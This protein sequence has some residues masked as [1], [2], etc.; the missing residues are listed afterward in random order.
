[1]AI[2][3]ITQTI[4][5][6]SL[7]LVPE[8]TSSAVAVIGVTSS[9]TA[10]QVYAYQSADAI[11]DLR[12]DLG[13]G[14][15]VEAAAYHLS[16]NGS[17]VYV[18]RCTDSGDAANGSVTLTGSGVSPGASCTGSALDNYDVKVK[19]IAGG[20]VATATFQISFDGGNNYSPTYTTAATVTTW[21][22]ETG[23][24]I[25]FAAGTYV[26]GD[27]YSWSST[28]DTYTEAHAATAITALV[29]ASYS[30][31]I[32]HCAGL[33]A[34]ANDAAKA[35]QFEDVVSQAHTS[36]ATAAS[37]YRYAMA[38]VDG[39]D[40]ANSS[41]GDTEI[42]SAVAAVD[43]N[44]SVG[45]AGF[46][47]LTSAISGRKYKRPAAWAAVARLRQIPIS[48]HI[49]YVGR[50]SLGASV[51]LTNAAGTRYLDS[52][53]RPAC[54]NAR[55][56]ALR[57]HIVLPGVYF[58]DAH[59][60]AAATSD[61]RT[62]PNRRVIDRASTVAYT[63]LLPFLNSSVRVS[64]STGRILEADAVAIEKAVEQ[65]LRAAIT[66]PGFASDV[67]VSVNRN[68]NILSTSTLRVKTRVVPLGYANQI[69]NEIG[70]TNPALAVVST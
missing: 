29:D 24:T 68:D 42:V 31:G 36:L 53:V 16:T 46:C 32:L 8:D 27:I 33:H 64:A 51:S 7:G 30:W 48:E 23:L 55:L 66:Q 59:T 65:A 52:R 18:V 19:I 17:A 61:L 40:V 54:N 50:G 38:V 60:M 20:A 39:P 37:A 34:G 3:A 22:T 35:A 57:S 47:D 21:A 28:C 41:A 43:S 13:Y 14:P 10:N 5:E 9:G 67:S 70:F 11:D 69:E 44:R 6:N 15:A 56:V 25:T 1:M 62:I 26:A 45:V 2:P 12:S 58:T 63:S 4:T 49:G